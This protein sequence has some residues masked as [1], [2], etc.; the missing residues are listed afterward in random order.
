MKLYLDGCDGSG[1][2]TLAD[3][4]SKRFKIDKFTLTKDSEKSIQRYLELETYKNV[5]HDRTFLSEHVYPEIF[6][7]KKW[8]SDAQVETL[9]N[10]YKLDGMMIICTSPDEIIA[11]RLGKRGDEFEEVLT[12]ICIINKAYLE[13]AKQHNIL[14][15]DTDRLSFEMIGDYIERRIENGELCK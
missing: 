5:V 2:T 11:S 4:L 12:N 15:V 7:R 6:G 1:K 10:I 3:Y 14:V 8:M 13:I 9:I